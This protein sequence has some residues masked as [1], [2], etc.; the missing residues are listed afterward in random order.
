MHGILHAHATRDAGVGS[1]EVAH[2]LRRV[3][4]GRVEDDVR[5]AGEALGGDVAPVV[6]IAVRE[7]GSVH[8]R[9]VGA[10]VRGAAVD[11]CGVDGAAVGAEGGAVILVLW[12]GVGCG[13]GGG[14]DADGARGCFEV[15]VGGVGGVGGGGGEGEVDFNAAGG[16]VDGEGVAE[17]EVAFYAARGE[18]GCFEGVD[19]EGREGLVG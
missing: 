12:D 19:E 15:E 13:D 8:A 6:E 16:E 10:E 3:G 11:E 5:A 7:Q 2:R 18:D 17:G 1:V 9:G 4:E 14:G